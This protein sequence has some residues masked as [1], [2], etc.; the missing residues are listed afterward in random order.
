[1]AQRWRIPLLVLLVCV[2]G[3]SRSPCAEAVTS[4]D[5]TNM[6]TGLKQAG[7]FNFYQYLFNKAD[8][9]A[10]LKPFFQY[11]PRITILA[12]TDFAYLKVALSWNQIYNNK[13]CS[14]GVPDGCSVPLI[15]YSIFPYPLTYDQIKTAPNGTIWNSLEGSAVQKFVPGSEPFW[16]NLAPFLLGPESAVAKAI[17]FSALAG[18]ISPQPVYTSAN[19]TVLGLSSVIPPADLWPNGFPSVFGSFGGWGGNDGEN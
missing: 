3:A 18:L 11:I 4:A 1:M 12:P 5:F 17:S 13:L 8:A 9:L 7:F 16:A 2:L 10:N 19:I 15:L 6:F 14:Y